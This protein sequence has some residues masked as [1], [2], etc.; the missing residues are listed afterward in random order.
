M[1]LR[2]KNL[3][4]SRPVV[5]PLNTGAALRLSPGQLSDELPDVEAK[6]NARVDRLR[7]QGV[8]EVVGAEEEDGQPEAEAGTPGKDKEGEEE[9]RPRSRR[10]G[11][12]AKQA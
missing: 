3:L 11:Q 4:T 7:Q 8:I 6:D 2:I 10:R 9:Q 1:P 5:V 12:S